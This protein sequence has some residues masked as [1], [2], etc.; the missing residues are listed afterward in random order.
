MSFRLSPKHD[1][2]LLDIDGTLLDIAPEPDA[3]VVPPSLLK[4]LGKLQVKLG[5]ALALVTGRPIENIDRL[6]HPLILPASG[7]HGAEW[8]IGT[9]L[10]GRKYLPE[11]IRQA[12]LSCASRYPGLTVEDKI[13]SIA[14]HYRNAPALA[15]IVEQFLKEI[16]A[17][18]SEPLAAL[19]GK[20]VFELVYREYDK[21]TAIDLLM[22]H[23]P[24]AGRRPVFIGDDETD[25]F[26]LRMCEK[27]SGAGARVGTN[28]G[29][30]FASP[31]EVRRWI[32]EQANEKVDV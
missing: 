15:Q 12:V 22:K 32:A 17:S 28:P 8:R 16:L 11:A 1:A 31:A 19:K 14:V 24:F 26:A 13:Y 20:M 29:D 25:D 30:I 2:L 3:V 5:G 21:G 6:F 18:S 9:E 10:R 23:P 27:L 7:V 4:D